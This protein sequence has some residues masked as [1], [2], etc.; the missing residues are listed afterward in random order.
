M[1][2][3]HG[4]STNTHRH[5]SNNNRVGLLKNVSRQA[6]TFCC[7]FGR[8]RMPSRLICSP[9]I[10]S[11]C[12]IRGLCILMY[13]KRQDNKPGL[14]I[15]PSF[16]SG[17]VGAWLGERSL[18][19]LL[20]KADMVHGFSSAAAR[21]LSMVKPQYKMSPCFLISVENSSKK[22]NLLNSLHYSA[23]NGVLLP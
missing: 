19:A 14:F 3:I 13:S 15:Y 18:E 20:T 7:W 6:K 23:H 22:L 2:K 16:Q 11:S 10:F 17:V 8:N 1:A 9:T 4:F 21:I 12:A 5:A